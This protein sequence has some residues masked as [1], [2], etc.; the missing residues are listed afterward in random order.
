[1]IRKLLLVDSIVDGPFSGSPTNVIYL[2]NPIERFKMASLAAEFG[3]LE[4]VFILPYGESFLLRFFTPLIELKLGVNASL[5][6]AHVIFE[7]GI[8]PPNLPVSFLTQAGEIIVR[9]LPPD[10]YTMELDAASSTPLD[11]AVTE[12]FAQFLGFSPTQV[13]W[14]IL[15]SGNMAVLA[16]EDLSVLKRLEPNLLEIMK[17][18]VD[19]VAVTAL[20]KQ[21]GDVDYYLRAF[22]PK[23]VGHREEHVSGSIN[24]ALG[25]V[26]GKI[27]GKKELSARQLSKR[28][29]L[30]T[31]ELVDDERVILKGRALTVLRSDIVL[32][33]LSPPML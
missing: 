13:S 19:G 4:T 24:L 27:L 26:W 18:K 11:K 33:D 30:M 32:E 16:V 29:G 21:A 14:G 10:S 9:H 5:A 25:Q 22:R 8:T 7:I 31:I 23:L 20:A 12:S 15:T 17:S 6:A 1:M 28:G 3:T 2:L